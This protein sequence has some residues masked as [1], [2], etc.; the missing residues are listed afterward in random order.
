M[1]ILFRNLETIAWILG[2]LLLLLSYRWI[3]WLIGVIIVPDDSI[4]IVTKRFVLFGAHRKLA[5]GRILA[6]EGEAGYQA[7]TLAPGLHWAL[8]PWQYTVRRE[9]FVR[10]PV[11]KIGLVEACDGRP[12]ASGH[13]LARRVDCISY[14]DARAFLLGGGE[15][16]PQLDLIPPGTYR[17][18]PLLF[19]VTLADMV[20]VPPGRIGVLEARD[21]R[22]LASG[23]IIARQVA[24]DA[25]QD[26]A[27]F[28]AN[29]GERGPQMGII[30]TGSYRINPVL[31]NVTLAEVLDI[32][33]NK[34]GI[35]TTREGKSL[36][37]GEIAGPAIPG[38]AM[39]QDPEAFVNN[40]GCKGLQ[41]Q[42]L[43]AG[44]Y[45]INPRF[46]TV[47]IVDMIEVPIAHVGVVIA[48][49]G[50]EGKDVTGDAFRHG[51]LVSKGEKGVWIE[52]LDP[53]KYPI[54]PYTHKVSNVPTAN[55]V[56]NWATGKSE[57][58]KLDANLS[59]ITVRSADGFRFNLDVSQII[60]IPRSDA[61][62]VIARFGDM[63]ALVTQV[64]EPT[65]GNYFRN[66]AQ[67]SDIIDFLR[68][69]TTRQEEARRSISAA[70]Q[71]YNVGAVD[72]L[73]GDIVP[74]EE[75]MKTLTD[76]KIAEQEQVTFETQRTAQEMRQK[77]EQA[78]ALAATQA[79]VVDAE[80]KVS[81][82][83]FTARAAVASAQG[84]AR[85]KTINAEAD[86]TVTRTVGT[87]E[88]DR[89]LAIGNAEAEV[90]QRKI[91]S[92]ESG[93]Y[94]VVQVA[95]ALAKAGVK[96]VPDIVAGGA[97]GGNSLVDVLLGNLLHD[98][99]RTEQA[100]AA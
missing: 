41:E 43:L 40:G 98:R 2:I 55:V 53:G 84:E 70:L 76:R 57:A 81:I 96:L 36:G 83:E 5:D 48:F 91:N 94:A 99:L 71:E 89:T 75:L 85:A 61:P 18:N 51:N 27:A 45:F 33:E 42:V 1:D 68:N 11:G 72:T 17:I 90:I 26:G 47:E 35:V 100:R 7:D 37:E 59:T 97:T 49:V 67:G 24:C 21:G 30:G 82:A 25:F 56:L 16:G 39:F 10:V 58:H 29:G 64:L 73:I 54:N 74:P 38:H 31:F 3:L 86:A 52:P 77:L 9:P 34:I 28:L 78:T 63:S 95:E 60:H 46:A 92:M 13:I 65:I 6:L 50:G 88:A 87:A 20:S 93:N 23:R 62:K 69:R 44:R 4:G 19:Q 80:R 32:P 12:L 14:Q 8:W 66:A 15:R 22:P 79:T